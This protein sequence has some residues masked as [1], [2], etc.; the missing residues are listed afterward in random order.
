MIRLLAL[1]VVAT[2]LAGCGSSKPDHPPPVPLGPDDT[3]LPCAAL[4]AADASLSADPL[5]EIVTGDTIAACPA[6]GL[7][8]PLLDAGAVA[9]RCADRADGA[10]FSTSALCKGDYW[11]VACNVFE[12]GIGDAGAD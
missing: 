7:Y 4:N 3:P 1:L 8:C 5:D 9:A 11:R 10:P 12:G 2:A 6:D